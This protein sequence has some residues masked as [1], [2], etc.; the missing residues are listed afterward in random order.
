MEQWLILSYIFNYI[1]HDRHPK[2]FHKLNIKGL[3]QK[4][5]KRR[6]NTKEEKQMSEL[7]FGDI[8]QKLK[9]NIKIYMKEFNQRY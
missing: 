8:L 9:K 3:N 4:S 7:D 6:S 5:H 2:N 1:Q